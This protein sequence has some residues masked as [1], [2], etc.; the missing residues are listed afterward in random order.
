M[1]WHGF[2]TE[3]GAG[4]GGAHRAGTQAWYMDIT[5][6]RASSVMGGK[7]TVYFHL[8]AEAL[9]GNHPQDASLALWCCRGALA[10]TGASL[11][12]I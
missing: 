6:E 9:K 4:W 11:G 1:T 12:H 5:E 7:E 3:S 8:E 10:P 2:L